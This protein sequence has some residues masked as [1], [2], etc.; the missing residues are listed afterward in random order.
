M[1][2]AKLKWQEATQQILQSLDIA[3]EYALLGVRMAGGGK[4]KVSAKGWMQCHAIDREDVSPSA[5]INVGDGPMRGRYKDFAGDGKTI[6]LFDFAATKAGK[7]GGDWKQARNHYAR[8]TGVKLP[9]GAEELVADRLELYDASFG[10]LSAYA[11]GKPGVTVRAL[12]AVGAKGA[13]WPKGLSA[14]KTNH[15][16]AFPMYG[17]AL[18]DLEPTAWHLVSSQPRLKIRVFQGKGNPDK[19]E[20]TLTL[21]EYGLMGVDALNRLADAEVVWIVEGI[22]DLLALTEAWLAWRDEVGEVVA[23]K[24][25]VISAGGTS[26]QCKPEWVDLFAGKDCR[27]CFDV[28]DKDDAGQSGAKAWARTLLK[29]AKCVRNVALP[30]GQPQQMASMV[31]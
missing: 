5:G 16:L 1:A 23:N 15:V 4:A 24:H 22:S 18:L 20:K 13:R 12:K 8:Q 27:V 26:Y 11:A 3:A 7:F 21:G 30:L 9:E 31:A 19:L 2:D 25:V 10:V 17:S 28:G 6:N 29:V 14:E